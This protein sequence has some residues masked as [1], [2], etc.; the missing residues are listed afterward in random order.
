MSKDMNSRC[1]PLQPV[2]S[3]VEGEE[4]RRRLPAFKVGAWNRDRDA[5]MREM[6]DVTQDVPV[7]PTSSLF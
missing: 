5:V 3:G 2:P 4:A 7:C 1:T 6:E